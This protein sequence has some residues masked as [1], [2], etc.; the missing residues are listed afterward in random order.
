M[1][2]V[3][4]I[5]LVAAIGATA[6]LVGAA[7]TKPATARL[8]SNGCA[9]TAVHYQPTKNPGLSEFPWVQARP[10]RTF[11]MGILV[12]YP[13]TLRDARVN[14][15]DGLVLWT[16]G[17]RIV[18]KVV[19][20]AVKP[21]IVARRIGSGQSF[22][23]T[24]RVTRSGL[25]SALRF[26]TAGCWR[27]TL[28]TG[29]GAARVVALVVPPPARPACDATPVEPTGLAAVRPTT[30]GIAGAWTWSTTANEA[31]IYT[32]RVA[33]RGISTKVPWWVRRGWS[34]RLRLTGVRLDG[35]GQFRQ[36]FWQAGEPSGYP[37]GYHA[38][39][40]SIVNVPSAGCWL[41]TLRTGR[42]AGILVV[43]A[44]DR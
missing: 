36:A 8:V 34:A 19:R 42:L 29:R 41:F 21:T 44:I 16:R 4:L 10:A 22:R 15:S 7:V 27:L 28:R 40:P 35:R 39:F 18:W 32:H 5:A 37:A 11:V 2:P 33:P 38:V 25:V 24:L 30:A 6:W 31:L 14:R 12:S 3:R 20:S 1:G 17:E 26:P 9:A 23:T 13:Q 43:R